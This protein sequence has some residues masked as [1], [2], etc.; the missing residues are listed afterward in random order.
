MHCK[1]LREV[2]K[3]LNDALLHNII[4]NLKNIALLYRFQSHSGVPEKLK[5]RPADRQV[6]QVIK[7]EASKPQTLETVALYT[8]FWRTGG[9]ASQR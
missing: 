8:F 9:R 6:C 4:R 3:S 7:N 5:F 1:K 2:H